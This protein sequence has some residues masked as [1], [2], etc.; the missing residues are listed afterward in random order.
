MFGHPIGRVEIHGDLDPAL[1]QIR[2][3]VGWIG[4]EGRIPAVSSPPQLVPVHVDD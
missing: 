1:L 3:G 2:E 4:K